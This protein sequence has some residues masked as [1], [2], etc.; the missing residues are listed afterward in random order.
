MCEIKSQLQIGWQS[1][2]V[3]A[4]FK[5]PAFI[6]N[7]LPPGTL[8]FTGLGADNMLQVGSQINSQFD[9]KS[10]F[11][12]PVLGKRADLTLEVTDYD[13]SP[14]VMYGAMKVIRGIHVPLART[15]FAYNVYKNPEFEDSAVLSLGINFSRTLSA[16]AHI[17]KPLMRAWLDTAPRKFFP[18]NGRAA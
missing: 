13:P 14:D 15:T 2:E 11:L 18:G 5:D 16:P 6:E 9:V 8:D 10:A 1:H 17:A 3:F 7:F 4:A 12:H